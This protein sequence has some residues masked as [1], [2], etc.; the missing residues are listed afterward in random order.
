MTCLCVDVHCNREQLHL[1]CMWFNQFQLIQV[2]QWGKCVSV[3]SGFLHVGANQ[4]HVL[5]LS[6]PGEEGES[7]PG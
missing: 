1:V 3:V 7:E 5:H 6:A 2:H 4:V